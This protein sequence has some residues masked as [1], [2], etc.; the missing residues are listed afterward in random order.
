MVTD[1]HRDYSA[2]WA[3]KMDSFWV[4]KMSSYYRVVSGNLSSK[5]SSYLSEYLSETEEK[6]IEI[7]KNKS[8][9]H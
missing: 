9:L 8:F 7:N 5:L 2:I 1:F 4:A 3:A 6:E